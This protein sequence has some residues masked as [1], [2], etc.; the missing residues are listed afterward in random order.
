MLLAF[1]RGPFSLLTGRRS[2]LSVR[3]MRAVASVFLDQLVNC[4]EAKGNRHG[5][6]LDSSF[7]LVLER[8]PYGGHNQSTSVYMRRQGSKVNS[9]LSIPIISDQSF[10]NEGPSSMLPVKSSSSSHSK[11][12]INELASS[13]QR[14]SLAQ[15]VINGRK[16]YHL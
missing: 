3:R 5:S 4:I 9:S 14:S 10:G 8:D 7:R 6:W 11:L 13:H 15:S 16:T 2:A 12:S 1:H